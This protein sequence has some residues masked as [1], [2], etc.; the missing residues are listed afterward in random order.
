MIPRPFLRFPLLI[1]KFHSGKQRKLWSP[2]YGAPSARKGTP[3]VE[4]FFLRSLQNPKNIEKKKK[5]EK[6]LDR[7][8]KIVYNLKR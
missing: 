1:F 3:Y 7:E 2:L 5:F 6:P 4:N 8:S